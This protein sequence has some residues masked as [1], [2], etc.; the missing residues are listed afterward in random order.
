MEPDQQHNDTTA[1]ATGASSYRPAG[2][3]GEVPRGIDDV[4]VSEPTD[5]PRDLTAGAPVFEDEIDQVHQRI[6]DTHQF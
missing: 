6:P 1:E 5:Q 4:P 2:S 3:D